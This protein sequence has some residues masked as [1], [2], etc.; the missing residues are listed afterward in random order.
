MAILRRVAVW[1]AALYWV[2]WLGLH[3]LVTAVGGVPSI[4]RSFFALDVFLTIGVATAV[5]WVTRPAGRAEWPGSRWYYGPLVVVAL[6]CGLWPMVV[7]SGVPGTHR[8]SFGDV[9]VPSGESGDRYLNNHG[10]RVRSLTEDE[11]QRVEAWRTVEETGMM[12]GFAGM[13][14]VGA[15]YFQQVRSEPNS[16]Q[17]PTP[18]HN[19][20]PDAQASDAAVRRN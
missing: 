20:P 18:P 2:C 14:L 5:L 8:F 10:R 4:P 13:I 9:G 16:A 17:Q 1:V 15:L 7:G 12:A 3:L 19:S 11:F 6:I